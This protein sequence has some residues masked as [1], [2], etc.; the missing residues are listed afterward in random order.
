MSQRFDR[1]DPTASQVEGPV[2]A[3]GDSPG[4]LDREEVY[5][6]RIVRLSLDSVRFPGGSEGRLEMI[7][8]PGAAAVLPLLDPPDHPDPRILLVRQYRYAAG[9]YLYE[10]PAGMP[11]D[12]NEGWDTCARRELA[13]ETGFQAGTLRYLTRIFTTPGFT[14]EVIHLFV[15][16]DLREGQ[17]DRDADE[18]LSVGAIPL[19]QAVE[20]VA[21]GLIVDAKS[22]SSLLFA[23]RFLTEAWDARR[24][25]P[26]RSGAGDAS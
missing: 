13:E 14:D 25:V 2:P 5:S 10:V 22:V 17:A 12:E 23:D 9:G 24:P 7:R 11:E 3:E 20:G 15:A 19:S 18:F 16:S 26:A 4:C 6:G 21:R 1:L 8:H